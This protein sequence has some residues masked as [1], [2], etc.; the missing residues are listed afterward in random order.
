M[1]EKQ[2]FNFLIGLLIGALVSLI[3]W[4]WQKSTRAEDGAFVLLDRL[5]AAEDRARQLE[6]QLGRQTAVSVPPLLPD[7]LQ[8]VKGIGSV[9]ADRLQ[10][11]GIATFADLAQL[12]PA[13]LGEILNIHPH[14][15]QIILAEL[16]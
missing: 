2:S 3:I 14:R 8:D 15:A 5:K 11:A 9:F 13:R 7:N 10:A 1:K 4:Y 12:S 6:N 16:H